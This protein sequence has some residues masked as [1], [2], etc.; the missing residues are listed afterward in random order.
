MREGVIGTWEEEEKQVT[1]TMRTAAFSSCCR[2][3]S[4]PIVPPP[5]SCDGQSYPLPPQPGSLGM[6]TTTAPRLPRNLNRPVL[7]FKG[8]GEETGASE[9]ASSN[10]PALTFLCGD[11]KEGQYWEL[12]V[13]RNPSLAPHH[14]GPHSLP[15]QPSQLYLAWSCRL[16]SALPVGLPLGL[17]LCHTGGPSVPQGK[18]PPL[19]LLQAFA[20]AGSSTEHVL[21]LLPSPKRSPPH[22]VHLA[23]VSVSLPQGSLP[24]RPWTS[25]GAQHSL[26]LLI[27]ICLLQ[28]SVNP[29]QIKAMSARHTP[30][31]S[32][33]DSVL[34]IQQV[35]KIPS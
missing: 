7:G 33:Y 20:G 2:P 11:D 4:V 6:P 5:G 1:E 9:E 28:K 10:Q 3:P 8:G 29:M 22:F 17:G 13:C 31:F 12:R 21:S 26:S 35:L 16:P 30:H 19:L 14:Q 15:P 27:N 23:P 18:G 32:G 25:L 34:G 24:A